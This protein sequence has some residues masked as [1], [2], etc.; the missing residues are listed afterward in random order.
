MMAVLSWYLVVQLLGV[1]AFVLTGPCFDRLPDS[2]Y[3]VS[4]SLGILMLGLLLWLGTALG[5]L[6][7]EPGGALL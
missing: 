5:L 4:K 7:N 3:G 1:T 6:R 2:G